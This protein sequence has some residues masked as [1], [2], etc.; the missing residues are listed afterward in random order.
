M[1]WRYR[2]S[3]LTLCTFAFFVTMVGRLAISPVIPEI[4]ETFSV[5]NAVVGFALTGMWLAYGLA[6]YPSGVLAERYG[7]RK[8]IL[9]AVVRYLSVGGLFVQ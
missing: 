6:Q 2:D 4:I 3:V 8:I 5:S 1:P 9:I 7:E